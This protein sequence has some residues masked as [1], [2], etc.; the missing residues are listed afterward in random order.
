MNSDFSVLV[1]GNVWVPVEFCVGGSGV[2]EWCFF[3]S[4]VIDV[5]GPR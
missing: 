1:W 4:S 3:I 5:R 2:G